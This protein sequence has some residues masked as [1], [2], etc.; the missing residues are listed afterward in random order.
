MALAQSVRP[1]D[2]CPAVLDDSGF[3]MTRLL[4]P[5]SQRSAA[6][7]AT[8]LVLAPVRQPALAP[9]LLAPGTLLIGS[10][11]ACD[12]CIR[13]PGVAAR[14]VKVEVTAHAVV[15]RPLDPRTWLNDWPIK[16]SKLRIG[17]RLAV[18]P[19]M[20]HVRAATTDEILEQLPDD[21]TAAIEEPAVSAPDATTTADELDEPL[22]WLP[23]QEHIAAPS[24]EILGEWVSAAERGSDGELGIEHRPW[25]LDV[26]S[27]PEVAMNVGIDPREA[28]RAA[29]L[30][31][32]LDRERAAWDDEQRERDRQRAA[33]DEARLA[34]IE[35]RAQWDDV[36]REHE[37]RRAEWEED[38]RAWTEQQREIDQ[39]RAER[40]AELAQW[41]AERADREAERAAWRS[42][43]EAH[44]RQIADRERDLACRAE[45]LDQR[46][47]ELVRRHDEQLGYAMRWKQQ[48]EQ[49]QQ[50]HADLL[51]LQ[52]QL[53]G[54]REQLEQYVQQVRTDLA[55]E[56]LGQSAAWSEWQAVHARLTAE[57]TAQFAEVDARRA[58]LS[59]R[60]TALENDRAALE[61]ARARLDADSQML[62]DER[63]R[64]DDARHAIDADTAALRDDLRRQ[65]GQFAAAV[66]D[67]AQSQ[68]EFLAARKELQNERR[69]FA[70]QQAAW[71]TEREAL[72]NELSARR[73][74]LEQD[75]G[76]LERQHLEMGRLIVALEQELSGVGGECE[77]LRTERMRLQAERDALA[78]TR[79][80]LSAAQSNYDESRQNFDA[81]SS[82]WQ[83]QLRQEQAQLV[84]DRQQ[85][86]Q[87]HAELLTAHQELQRERRRFAEER[88]S[89]I[90]E[91]DAECEELAAVQQQLDDQLAA[92]ETQH[93]ELDRLRETLEREFAAVAEEREQLR[94]QRQ[95]REQQPPPADRPVTPVDVAEA[96]VASVADESPPPDVDPSNAAPPVSDVAAIAAE[97][98]GPPAPSQVEVPS[99]VEQPVADSAVTVSLSDALEEPSSVWSAVETPASASEDHTPR[100]AVEAERPIDDSVNSLRAELARLFNL[101][102]ES[103]AAQETEAGMFR[104]RAHELAAETADYQ[105]SAGPS[106]EESDEDV[107]QWRETLKSL[108]E[109]SAKLAAAVTDASSAPV[110]APDAPPPDDPPALPPREEETIASYMDQLLARVKKATLPAGAQTPEPLPRT[111]EE[112]WFRSAVDRRIEAA[113][114]DAADSTDDS[115]AAEAPDPLDFSHLEAGPAHV[116]DKDDVRAKLDSFREV[117]NLSART[118]LKKHGWRTLRSEVFLHAVMISTSLAG[119][120]AYFGGPAWG[121][122]VQWLPGTACVIVAGWSFRQWFLSLARLRVWRRSHAHKQ[123]KSANARSDTA[124]AEAPH[125]SATTSPAE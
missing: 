4:T 30:L 6:S 88:E 16:E 48:Q 83:E 87:S 80:E 82:D 90:Q 122:P 114:L 5:P 43:Q 37:L 33:W 71:L 120:A 60:A 34:Q 27:T 28:E 81:E 77:D 24:A 112:V 58:E 11:A 40:N 21:S 75:A 100:A 19:V 89:W 104:E 39:Q 86:E 31:A 99:A 63:R 113:S 52:Q 101:P 54:E 79:A 91:R 66:H 118:A 20:F 115:P 111:S 25:F 110:P 23:V 85:Y 94:L 106:A 15:L 45:Q 105:A 74:Q 123:Q 124:K 78:E 35:E 10:D 38:Q 3:R 55:A 72:W 69:L 44:A 36:R 13:L 107:S 64:W 117:A 76:A 12:L 92:A 42:E 103:I 125:E 22:P 62:S 65:E 102:E 2:G 119:A 109:P 68:A 46:E 14:H 26:W 51:D 84:A 97:T 96:P 61:V 17:D 108:Y 8:T 70:E 57:L 49:W 50:R 1:V 9:R 53:R 93:A 18:G 121:G 59:Q 98:T 47:Q 67:R 29:E 95:Q 73:R 32:Q 7:P 41:Q 56:G 116:Q